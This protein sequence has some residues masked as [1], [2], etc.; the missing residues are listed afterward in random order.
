[1][2]TRMAAVTFRVLILK[3]RKDTVTDVCIKRKISRCCGG[4]FCDAKV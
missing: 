4:N 3:R 2:A 1:M